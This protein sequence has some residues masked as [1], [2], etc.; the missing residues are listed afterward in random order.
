MHEVYYDN[1]KIYKEATTLPGARIGNPIVANELLDMVRTAGAVVTSTIALISIILVAAKAPAVP[2]GT[3]VPFKLMDI[4]VKAP[5]T[6]AVKDT[7]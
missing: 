6:S 2:P 4:E 7:R 5:I 1:L 3:G